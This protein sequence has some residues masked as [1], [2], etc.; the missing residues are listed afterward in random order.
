[1]PILKVTLKKKKK[2]W[3]DP[4]PL[5]QMYRS[6]DPD[7]YQNVTDP[8]HYPETR[9]VPVQTILVLVEK[10][11]RPIPSANHKFGPVPHSA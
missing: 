7:S 11:K 3:Q 10:I 4:H 5:C 6:A 8:Q 1:M 9:L 2:K